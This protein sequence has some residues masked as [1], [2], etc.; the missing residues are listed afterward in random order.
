MRSERFKAELLGGHKED[1]VEVPFDPVVRWQIPTAPLWRGRRGHRVHGSLNGV[2]FESVVVPRI[3]KF[4]LI[5]SD[6][7]RTAAGVSTGDIVDVRIAGVLTPP[8][9]P[10]RRRQPRKRRLSECPD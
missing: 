3:R 10:T 4:F 5:V 1:A 6:Q 9:Q 7:L 8:T 2:E